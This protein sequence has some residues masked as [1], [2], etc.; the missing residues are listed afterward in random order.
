LG[1]AGIVWEV[2]VV[3]AMVPAVAGLTAVATEAM[4]AAAAAI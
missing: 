1:A 3:F 2:V 4:R